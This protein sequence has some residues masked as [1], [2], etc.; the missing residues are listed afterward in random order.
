MSRCTVF[1]VVFCSNS[2]R[3]HCRCKRKVEL[4]NNSRLYSHYSLSESVLDYVVD[5]IGIGEVEPN[6]LDGI[7]TLNKKFRNSFEV[8]P[9]FSI[10]HIFGEFFTYEKNCTVCGF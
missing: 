4:H 6:F 10:S 1:Y 9:Q 2:K 3:S 5:I 8:N 7:E